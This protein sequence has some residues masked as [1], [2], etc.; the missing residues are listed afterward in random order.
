MDLRSNDLMIYIDGI[1]SKIIIGEEA[2]SFE[3][4]IDNIGKTLGFVCSRP[5]KDSGGF[6]PDNLWAVGNDKYFVI[7]CKSESTAQTIKKDY[8]NQLSGHVNWFK[9]KYQNGEKCE[10]II[11][12]RSDC[13]DRL[14]SPVCDMHIVTERELEQFRMSIRAFF[15]AIC[16]AG[17]INDVDRISELLKEYKLRAM[18]ILNYY[19][20]SY[21]R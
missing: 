10:P 8:C 3:H 5:D 18:D 9:E 11:I 19:T 2:E 1:L 12:H 6:G 7:E 21:R 17:N 15:A 14:A 16:N 4:A 20:V 13:L